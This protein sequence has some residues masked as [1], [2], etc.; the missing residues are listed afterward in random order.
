MALSLQAFPCCRANLSRAL[1]AVYCFAL[2]GF[3]VAGMAPL[4]LSVG[5]VE[6]R[7]CPHVAAY[8]GNLD[9]PLDPSG[10]FPG[11]IS[12]H[13]EYYPP[14]LGGHP[15]GTLVATEG[16]PG[17]STT[18]SRDDYLDLFQPLREHHAVL[19]M[20]NRGTGQSGAIDCHALQTADKLTVELIGE[21]GRSLGYRAP[22]YSTAYAADDLAAVLDA[23]GLVRIDLY[24]DSY[25]TYL[26]QVFAVRHPTR[27]RSIVL[28][29][30]YP[31]RG[32]DYAWYPNY[33]PAMRDKFN[34]ACRRFAPCALLPGDSIAHVLPALQSLRAQPFPASAADREGQSRSF[35]ANASQ[36]AIVMYGA[37]PALATVRELDAA[38]RAFIDGDRAPLLR[39]MAETASAVDSRDPTADPTKWS[40]GLAAVVSCQD[41]PQI[42]DMRL[43]PA[44][45]LA[46]RDRAIALRKRALPDTYAPFSIDEYRGMPLDYSFIDTCV[47][48][49]VAPA[50]HPASQVIAANAPYPTIPALII[51]GEF[52]N[53]TSTADGAAVAAEFHGTQIR[54]ANSFHVNA[55]PRARSACA[56][57]ITRRFIDTLQALDT[58]CAGEVPA[59]RLVPKFAVHAAEL[60]PAVAAAGNH[61]STIEL[62]WVSAAV[63]TVGDVLTRLPGN[64]ADQG[65]GLRGGSFRA[66]RDS[67]SA[68]LKLTSVRW[69]DD[70]AVSGTVDTPATRGGAVHATVRVLTATGLHGDLRI[71]WPGESL[72]ATAEIHGTLG[73]ATV[74][75]RTPAP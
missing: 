31:L 12:I 70:L 73:G 15:S 71:E 63:Q 5:A 34:I 72:A 16:G 18:E 60:E 49:P 50:S 6:L 56:A 67:A 14:F 20:D 75:A 46:D 57:Q 65:V 13:F 48:W 43:E 36:L 68:H 8:C 23:L 2:S 54:I 10:V 45:R 62:H 51:S 32:P 58:S 44:V 37:A 61:A 4:S 33:A 59:V 17:Y 7:R 24:G 41:P 69:A 28:D 64:S 38:A 3:S 21:C 74:N 30:S 25:G 42:F 53:M 26:E 27:L 52:D 1:I 35:T 19:L 47:E 11:R 29:G 22:L 39:L 9:R 66:T 55:L 40:A